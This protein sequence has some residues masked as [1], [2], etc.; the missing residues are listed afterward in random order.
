MAGP[1]LEAYRQ[2]DV[3]ESGFRI[4][5]DLTVIEH[6]GGS[7]KVDIYL[8]RSKK[9]GGLVA[10][11]ILRSR[12]RIDFS[13]LEAV[14]E[15]GHRLV[16][17]RHP[18]V[19]EGYE[20][21]LEPYPR[22]VMQHL[23]GQ[24]LSNTFFQ[25]NYEAFDLGDVVDVVVQ[26]ADALTYIHGKGLLHL[27]VKPSNAMY[28]DG[29]VTLFDFSVAEEYTP[30]RPLRDNA[31]TTEYMAPE[32]TYRREVG[33]ETDVFGLGV[34]FYRLLAGEALP[35]AVVKR[36]LPDRE[37]D[38]PRRQLDYDVPVVSP[39]EMNPKVPVEIDAVAMKAISPS[40]TE[41]Y[42]TPE[43]LLRALEDAQPDYVPD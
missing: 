43:E 40:R 5:G 34:V 13:S 9:H 18:N 36:P 10:C 28:H 39:S 25:G 41:R 14:M 8:C 27:D 7:R 17:L 29:H 37:D 30:D 20:V 32:Q 24:T 26:L 23:L 15:E 31:G 22:V 16:R 19:V 33:Y 6:L 1:K 11:K 2:Y 21:V 12:Y 38:T 42:Q 3:F 35:Y 4:D